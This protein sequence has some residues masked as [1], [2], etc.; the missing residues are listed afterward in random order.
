MRKKLIKDP[1]KVEDSREHSRTGEKGQTSVEYILLLAAMSVIIFSLLTGIRDR[2]L[3]RVRPC[4]EN[5]P[6]LGCK[7]ARIVDS[8]GSTDPSFRFFRLRK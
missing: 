2:I 1:Y 6:T 5:D 3:P 8:M 7:L 4:P